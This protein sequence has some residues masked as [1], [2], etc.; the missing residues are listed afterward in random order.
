MGVIKE[1]LDH[2]GYVND[3]AFEGDRPNAEE[4]T[5]QW[6]LGGMHYECHHEECVVVGTAWFFSSR[7]KNI[8]H[9]GTPSMLPCP[10]GI[11]A[12]PRDAA[13]SSSESLTPLIVI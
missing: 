4:V 1:G 10:C 3:E 2:V 6:S 12:Q 8:L 9:I 13:T 5:N 7:R 11:S